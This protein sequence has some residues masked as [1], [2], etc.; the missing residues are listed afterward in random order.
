MHLKAICSLVNAVETKDGL[1][2]KTTER[3][4]SQLTTSEKKSSVQVSVY[5]LHNVQAAIAI[6]V[7]KMD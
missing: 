7:A 4:T 1:L 3:N 5:L 6:S 2:T